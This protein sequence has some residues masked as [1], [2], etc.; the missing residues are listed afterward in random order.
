MKKRQE[1]INDDRRT[2]ELDIRFM[3]PEYEIFRKNCQEEIT[4]LE[5]KWEQKERQY[6]RD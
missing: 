1:T 4:E 3:G 5:K 6:F 2:I